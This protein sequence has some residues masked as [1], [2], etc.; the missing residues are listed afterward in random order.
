MKLRNKEKMKTFKNWNSYSEFADEVRYESRYIYSPKV[1]VFLDTLLETSRSCIKTLKKDYKLWR[2]KLGCNFNDENFA[3]PHKREKMVPLI[4]SAPEGRA[5]PKGIPYL[6]LATTKETAMAEIKP[7]KGSKIS[8]CEFSIQTDIKLIDFTLYETHA[9]CS[10]NEPTDENK[11]RNV[12]G[13]INNSFSKP[14]KS[15]DYSAD[16]ASTQIIA[17]LFKN[18]GFDGIKFKSSLGEGHNIMLFDINN[19]EPQSFELYELKDISFEFKPSDNVRFIY[20][21]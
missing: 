1:E 9:I 7:Y 18:K 15:T 21:L 13:E 2:A 12:W 20:V 19:A 14:I 4:D 5:N 8:V 6:Y 3:I 11:L 10:L 17:E 16:Y